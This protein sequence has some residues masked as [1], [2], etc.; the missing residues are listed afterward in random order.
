V[1]FKTLKYFLIATAA[2]GLGL[3]YWSFDPADSANFFPPCPFRALTGYLCPGCGSQRAV[4]H[5]LHFNI[6]SAF[7]LNPLLVFS[8]PYVMTG[9]IFENVALTSGMLLVR[10]K[11]YGPVA[12][13]IVLAIVIAFWIG[14]NLI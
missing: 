4:H 3:I 2:A 14:R 12:I 9:F 13:Q 5:L 1:G 10:K 8:I 7:D 6:Q 11:L